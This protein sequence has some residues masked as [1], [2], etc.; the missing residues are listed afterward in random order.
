MT[1]IRIDTRFKIV[2]CKQCFTVKL[3]LTTTPKLRP[4]RYYDHYFTVQIVFQQ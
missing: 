1:N 3:H 4:T 2:S